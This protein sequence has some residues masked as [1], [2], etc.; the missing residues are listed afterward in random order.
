MIGARMNSARSLLA[1]FGHW[2][3]QPNGNALGVRGDSNPSSQGFW[4]EH[5]KALDWLADIES[6]VNAL[7]ASGTDVS[8]YRKKIPSWYQGL[9]A[10]NTNW[11][12][13]TN[14][15]LVEEAALDVLQILA[16]TLDLVEWEPDFGEDQAN[17]FEALLHAEELIRG[18]NSLP[19]STRRYL[20]QLL[21]E[22]RFTL[23]SLEELGGAAARSASMQ[24]VGA[25]TT[26]ATTAETPAKRN[27][28]FKVAVELARTAGATAVTKAVEAGIDW[29]QSLT[30]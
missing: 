7:E 26:V 23:S 19:A 1:L 16:S 25:L 6:A 28:Y 2:E 5:R 4:A 30:Q 13:S 22:A 15:P 29:I 8:V 20:L 27:A 14:T 9:F 18:D 10:I 24:L 17:V 21:Q 3:L 11:T 12:P